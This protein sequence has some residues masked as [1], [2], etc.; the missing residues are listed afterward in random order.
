[1]NRRLI[2]LTFAACVV[3]LTPVNAQPPS[4]PGASNSQMYEDIEVLGRILDRALSLPRFTTVGVPIP[5]SGGF[6]GGLGGVDGGFGGAQGQLGLGSLSGGGMGFS[7]MGTSSGGLGLSGG[8]GG[9]SG[10]GLRY[11][12]TAP[13]TVPAYAKAQG[14][15][16]KGH[17]VVY[18][19]VLPPSKQESKPT[20]PATPTQSEWDRVRKQIRGENPPSGPLPLKPKEP[21]V[22]DTVLEVLA[23]NGH[24]FSQLGEQET[25]TVSIIFRAAEAP[26]RSRWRRLPG[27]RIDINAIYPAEFFESQNGPFASESTEPSPVGSGVG[28][29]E[30]K[31][32]GA[33]SGDSTEKSSPEDYEL[34]GDLHLKQGQGLEALRAYQQALAK[35]PDAQ[36]AAAMYLKLAQLYLTVQKDEAEARQAMEHARELLAQ[37]A[38]AA[39]KLAS[40]P[41]PSAELA[42]PLPSRLIISAPKRLLDQV[43]AGKMTL[44]DFKKKANVERLSFGAPQK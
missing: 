23:K 37:A 15:Y 13:V 36:H 40:K 11:T 32:P 12:S 31:K 10:G 25:L 7:G 4:Q 1:M 44:E 29:S 19:I 24:H 2:G 3:A 18:T 43:S 16:I 27:D 30:K 26:H 20:S 5:H 9:F 39:E 41:T 34:L 38:P 28:S 35:S 21:S 8:Q 42:Q 33:G 22:V 17:G 14:T 6:G